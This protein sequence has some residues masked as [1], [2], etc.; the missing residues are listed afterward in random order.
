MKIVPLPVFT[1]NSPKGF[2]DA[3]DEIV[4]QAMKEDVIV[5]VIQEIGAVVFERLTIEMGEILDKHGFEMQ[6]EDEPVYPNPL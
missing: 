2:C 3:I 5:A 6:V 1:H 4:N